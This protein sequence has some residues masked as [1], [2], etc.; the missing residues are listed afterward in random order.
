MQLTRE[1]NGTVIHSLYDSSNILESS[2]DKFSQDLI[3]TFKSGDQYKYP[4]VS[5]TD[6]TRFEGADSQGEVFSTHIKKYPFEKIGKVDSKAILI[7][8]ARIKKLDDDNL[9]WA[10]RMQI[11]NAAKNIVEACGTC[12]QG[13]TYHKANFDYSIKALDTLLKEYAQLKK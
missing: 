12:L 4:R 6:F 9:E 5:L 11:Y 8:A 13:E 3:I 1:V 2:Y 10:R 7:E